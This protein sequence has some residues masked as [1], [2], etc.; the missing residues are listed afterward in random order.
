LPPSSTAPAV[1]DDHSKQ[2]RAS[3]VNYWEL[4]GISTCCTREEIESLNQEA[5]RKKK[6]KAAEIALR[7]P[8]KKKSRFINIKV[9]ERKWF[10]IAT[11]NTIA[12]FNII[13]TFNTIYY[14]HISYL[15]NSNQIY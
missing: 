15:G 11:F 1:L 6:E 3:T 8:V 7:S 9:F 13:A 12:T 10:K 4:A 5:E 2:A 14:S